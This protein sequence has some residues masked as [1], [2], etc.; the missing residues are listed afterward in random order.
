MN[1]VHYR[2]PPPFYFLYFHQSQLILLNATIINFIFKKAI[3]HCADLDNSINFCLF[4]LSVVNN[5]NLSISSPCPYIPAHLHLSGNV[6]N[7]ESNYTHLISLSLSLRRRLRPPSL[8]TT[9]KWNAWMKL[10]FLHYYDHSH[11]FISFVDRS[12][13]KTHAFVEIVGWW[14]RRRFESSFG[15]IS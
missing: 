7:K 9:K 2:S 12:S 13:V 6:T 3:N 11:S 14:W 15:G 10:K 4:I 5:H 1:Y 8:P